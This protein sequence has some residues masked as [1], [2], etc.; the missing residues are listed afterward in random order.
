MTDE[1]IVD[2]YLAR[3]EQAIRETSDKY[4]KRL[5]NLSRQITGDEGVAEECV[6]DTYM[7]TWEKIPPH[8]P[9]S[10]FF[11]FVAR[12]TRMLSL[13]HFRKQYAAKRYANVVAL[14][15]ELEEC[16]SGSDMTEQ[17]VDDMHFKESLNSFL[18]GLTFEKRDVF[19]RRYWYMDDI[20]Q[21]ATRHNCKESRITTML[22]RLRKD[23]K[24]HLEADGITV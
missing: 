14:T 16:V 17:I 23:L 20:A 8:E 4:G 13:G 12:I 9:R 18:S 10:Y 2:L 6:N 11:A 3:D 15:K 1:R 21:I 24:D 22:L 5:Y 19:I 7:E